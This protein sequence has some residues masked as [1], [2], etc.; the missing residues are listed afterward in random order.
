MSKISRW[1]F[2][3]LIALVFGVG[4]AITLTISFMQRFQ[5]PDT[6]LAWIALLLA[7]L[8]LIQQGIIYQQGFMYMLL[9]K[10]NRDK[11]NKRQQKNKPVIASGRCGSVLKGG[12]WICVVLLL[13][14]SASLFV[15][16]I[17]EPSS[18]ELRQLINSN[19]ELQDSTKE[20]IDRID[21]L[22]ALMESHY[23]APTD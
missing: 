15:G 21:K 9:D 7:L 6:A 20:L 13:L 22:I 10:C 2:I 12:Y 19:R 17:S 1:Y 4:V 23:V 5:N 3:S 14:I 16:T 18:S 11:V 8:L